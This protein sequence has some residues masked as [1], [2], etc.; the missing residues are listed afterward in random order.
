MSVTTLMFRGCGG[1]L[2][3]GC[4]RAE[5]TASDQSRDSGHSRESGAETSEPETVYDC[6]KSDLQVTSDE[7]TLSSGCVQV[8]PQEPPQPQEVRRDHPS[9]RSA[10][11]LSNKYA[12]GKKYTRNIRK[13]A[14]LC[15]RSEQVRERRLV[16]I[17][18]YLPG[19]CDSQSH[20]LSESSQQP[21]Q[22]KLGECWNIDKI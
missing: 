16:I 17:H 8:R 2:W 19:L 18:F 22:E 3:L 20:R 13:N 11:S 10:H 5:L 1:S 4:G 12:E 6:I 7:C 21:R 14:S 15:V 9:V